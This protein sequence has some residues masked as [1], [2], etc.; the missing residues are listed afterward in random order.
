MKRQSTRSNGAVA[1]IESSNGVGPSRGVGSSRFD[2][3]R[4]LAA[5]VR[6]LTTELS[7]ARGRVKTLQTELTASVCHEREQLERSRLMEQRLRRLSHK[8]LS[9]QEQERM[10][11]SRDLHDAIGQTLTGINV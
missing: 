8:L 3:P 9:A 2:E 10:R 1:P 4:K 7:A 11:I 6:R 5:R